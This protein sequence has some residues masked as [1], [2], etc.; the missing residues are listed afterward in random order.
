[1]AVLERQ[2]DATQPAPTQRQPSNPLWQWV[3]ERGVLYVMTG[4]PIIAII[5]GLFYRVLPYP[6]LL[7]LVLA[8]FVALP[9]WIT[10]RRRVS[11]NPDE[12]VHHL[13]KYGLWALAPAAMFSVSRIPLHYA[14]GIIYWHPWYDFG[15]ALT[16]TPLGHQD[17][18]FVG[19][20]LNLIQGWAMGLG[21]YILFKRH[22]LINVLL[23]IAV[24]ISALYSFDFAAYSR[25]GLKSPPYWHA[26]MAWAHFWMA[27]TLWF[28]P[29]FTTRVWPRLATRGRVGAVAV[30]ALIVLTPTVFAQWRAATWEFPRE[31]QI[32]N[33][34]FN[35]AGVSVVPGSLAL[36]STGTD[37][38]YHFT[39][40][41]GP[42]DYRNWFK[43][44]RSL[45]A[46][47]I[48]ITAKLSQSDQIIAWCA[49]SV[50]RLPSANAVTLP[51]NFAAV[52]KSVTY[53]DVPVTCNGPAAQAQSLSGNP[54]VNL[55]WAAQMTLI[56]G[57]EQQSKRFSGNQT[58][59]VSS[60]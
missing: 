20:I 51:E 15:N 17:T 55:D 23:Y 37:A 9:I 41:I 24:W 1:M 11:T 10:Y 21:F 19:G 16:G 46:S 3:L 47:S 33:A 52:M 45:D 40:R 53:T 30:L 58:V 7:V 42:R 18:L 49:T 50:D 8:S 36:L 43:Q 38:R 29:Q 14:I 59:A 22:S 60:T 12:P 28:M 5:G 2:R 32:D 27:L 48:Q 13:Y 57:R 39:L 31:T 26:S 4:T 56:G 34:A 35:R 25:V 44:M 54:Q 6:F